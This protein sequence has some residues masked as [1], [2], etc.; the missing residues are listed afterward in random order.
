M[1]MHLPGRFRRA[2]LTAASAILCSLLATSS[3]AIGAQSGGMQFTGAAFGPTPDVAIQ[4]AIGDAE[5]SASA[6]QLFT[7]RLI[8]E[9]LI[10]PGPSPAWSRNFTAEVTLACTP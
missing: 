5:V 8:G 2:P 1:Y 4:S 7:C 6:Y 10:F 3:P 9:P